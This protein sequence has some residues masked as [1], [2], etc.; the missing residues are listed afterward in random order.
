MSTVFFLLFLKQVKEDKNKVFTENHEMY[1]YNNW[2][3]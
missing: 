2:I 3:N 1:N